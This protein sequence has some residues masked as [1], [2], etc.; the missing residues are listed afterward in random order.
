LPAGAVRFDSLVT[1]AGGGAQNSSQISFFGHFYK[2][3]PTGKE[4]KLKELKTEEKLRFWPGM[5]TD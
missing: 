4:K 1:R 3:P 2:M 5:R